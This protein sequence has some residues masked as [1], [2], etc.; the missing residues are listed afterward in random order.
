MHTIIRKKLKK[1]ILFVQF[2]VISSL[3]INS[4]TSGFIIKRKISQPLCQCVSYKFPSSFFLT[5]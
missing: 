1:A 2:N 5:I 3:F 4:R